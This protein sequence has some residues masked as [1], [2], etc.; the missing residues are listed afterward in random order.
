MTITRRTTVHSLLKEYPFLNEYLAH[1]HPGFEKLAHP[2]LGRAMARVATMDRVAALAGTPV[3]TLLNDIATEVRRVTGVAPPI[4]AA[5]AAAGAAPQSVATSQDAGVAL[6]VTA[7]QEILKE[8]IRDLHAGHDM[9]ELKRRFAA[10]IEDV[11][12]TEIAAMEQ[13][14]IEEGMSE[15]EVKRLCDVHVQVF[16]EAL[17]EHEQVRAPAG[18]PLDTFMRE[19]RALREVLQSLRKVRERVGTP[20]RR[21]E[22][23]R[24]APAFRAAFERV[25]EIEKHYLRKENQLF[26]FLER[27][28]IEG[29]SKVMWALHDDV[30]AALR[31]VRA[32]LDRGDADAV[33]QHTDELLTLADEMIYKE[34]KIL[35][36][37]AMESL[38]DDE[39]AEI[40]RG[41]PEIG[42]ALIGEPSGWPNVHLEQPA[43]MGDAPQSAAGGGVTLAGGATSAPPEPAAGP[44]S[45]GT[46]AL[47][48]GALTAEQVNLI[49]RLL[50]VDI[51][52]VDENDQVRYYSEGERV[53]PRSP[54]IIGRKVQNCHPPASVQKVQ[55]ILDAFRA[56]QKDVAE[57]WLEIEGKFIHIRYFAVRDSDGTYRGTLEMVQDVTGIRALQGQR[58]LVDW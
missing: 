28:G 47:A 18:H 35:F 2:V 3:A 26:P 52:Y 24:L 33:A 16:A 40:R 22:W 19:N 43:P 10:L 13:R 9:E 23:E 36:P 20:P 46:L 57:F 32:A 42:Y 1:Y 7:R 12:A 17:D 41:E 53:F 44:P 55:E 38:S 37:M 49:L 11:D 56:G 29:P 39:W 45:G 34:E 58:R 6:D 14:L 25:R 48:T 8:I 51:T 15:Q 30:R 4:D 31:A 5:D 21:D 50:P 27:H 54:G